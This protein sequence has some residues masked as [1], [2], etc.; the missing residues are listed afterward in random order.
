MTS[1][2]IQN[3]QKLLINGSNPSV[4]PEVSSEETL[5]YLV[6][7]GV[8]APSHGKQFVDNFDSE[9]DAAYKS[10]QTGR[11]Y[12]VAGNSL[13]QIDQIGFLSKI[14]T[15]PKTLRNISF[16]E[17]VNNQIAITTGSALYVFNTEDNTL[18]EVESAN[19]LQIN[20]PN[21]CCV[22]D[23]IIIVSERNGTTFQLS[24]ANNALIFQDIVLQFT[25]NAGN[26]VTVSEIDNTLF[27]IGNSAIERWVT[28]P[29]GDEVFNKDNVYLEPYGLAFQDSF[30]NKFNMS[31]GIFTSKSG[32]LR[33]MFLTS[34]SSGFK[35]ISTPGITKKM[36]QYGSVI[37]ADLYEIDEYLYYEVV[38]SE[39]RSFIYNFNSEI[40]TESTSPFEQ[41][42][43][44]DTSDYA[45]YGNSIYKII[46]YSNDQLKKRKTPF[47]LKQDFGRFN[48]SNVR[49]WFNNKKREK[50]IINL[51]GTQDNVKNITLNHRQV[52]GKLIYDSVKYDIYPT[53]YQFSF[54]IETYMNVIWRGMYGEMHNG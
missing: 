34:S 53:S 8:L 36:K 11:W 38:F 14:A 25:A 4:F 20:S 19:G 49:F 15:I 47:I 50:G 42:I 52:D 41:V 16:A 5:N 13:Y 48:P 23:N 1:S 28:T 7:D 10:D 22:I 43:S 17:N 27:V 31:I 44:F 26:I 12:I 29:N 37:N 32:N 39:G 9:V 54:I 30:V 21:S 18:T 45:A 6:V 35:T 46:P 2:V 40:W 51:L 3:I 24:N 33:T